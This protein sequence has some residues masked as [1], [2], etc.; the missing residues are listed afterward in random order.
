VTDDRPRIEYGPW[1]RPDEITRVLPELLAL[2]TKVPVEGANEAL[3][4]EVETKRKTLMDFY[5][6]GLAAYGGDRETWGRTITGVQAA[7]P[8]NAYYSWIIGRD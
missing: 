8:A 5:T 4:A 6:A 1:V 3:S 2:Q 7:E